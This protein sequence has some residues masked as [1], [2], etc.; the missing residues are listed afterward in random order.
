MSPIPVASPRLL[1][2]V[3]NL[4][5]S[6]AGKE[7]VRDINFSIAPGEKLALV[8][9]SGSGKT[10]TALSLLRLVQDAEISGQAL[11][12]T[13]GSLGDLLSLP[14]QAL[15]GIRGRD[16]A[17]IFQEP[18]TALNPLFTVGDQIAEVLQ[19][20]QGLVQAASAQAA[21]KL[22]ADTGITE[23][24]RRANSFPHQLSGGQRQRAMIAMALACSPKLLLAD[25]PTTALDVTLRSQILDLLSDLQRRNGMAVLL[26]T[27]DL[28]LVRRF[29]DRV[30]VMENGHI[31]EQGSVADVF[32]RP[33]H[34]YT[35][36]LIDSKPV[37]D[38]VSAS[39]APDSVPVMQARDL[40]VGYPVAI[41]GIRGWFKSGE[42]VA[43]KAATFTILPGRTLGVVGESGSGKSTLALASLGLLKFSGQLQ[44]AGQSWSLQA[45]GNKA[46]RRVVQVVFQDPFSSLSPRMTVEAI[47]EEGLLVHEPLLG[48]GERRLR[49]EQ[50]L[51]DVGMSEAQF[52]GLLRRYPHEFSGG[53]RQRLAIARVLIINPSLLVLDEPTSA[54]DVTIQKQVL[55]LLQRLQRERGLSYL[56]ITH[57]MDVIRAMAHDVMVM[58]DGEI[59]ES[60][61]VQE[62]LDTPR[63]PYTQILVAQE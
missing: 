20:K 59:V 11:F 55:A 47:V 61:S 19:L 58:K 52:P 48:P 49:V 24:E 23:P 37:R 42:F 63:H 40:R 53:Q 34:P 44:A 30:A 31:V 57:D 56:L 32:A 10:V 27:H 41:A 3:K 45:A 13:S 26:I 22:I 50:S 36:K 62:V 60:G 38:V 2:E 21:I 46:I 17:M 28:N 12:E 9:E 39:L 16:I 43:V 54:L 14:E 29:A 1:L 15:R 25:E 4:R 18:M 35:R 33:R 7:V 6:F 5:V 8:G 51:T